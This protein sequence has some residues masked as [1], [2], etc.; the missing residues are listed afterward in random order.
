VAASVFNIVLGVLLI[1][2]AGLGVKG[3]AIATVA[4]QVGSSVRAG[5][6]LQR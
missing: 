1:F 2:G 4:S 3:A 5:A 6:R